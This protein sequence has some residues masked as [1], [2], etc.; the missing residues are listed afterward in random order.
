M[1]APQKLACLPYHRHAAV[2]FSHNLS[3]IDNPGIIRD[4]GA[5]GERVFR[6]EVGGEGDEKD[7]AQPTGIVLF[8][9]ACITGLPSLLTLQ[10]AAMTL[11]S[12][13][14]EP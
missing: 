13:N 5:N 7:Q 3:L 6:T 9:R 11:P 4:E 8:G 2:R 14:S 10:G 1:C 12:S